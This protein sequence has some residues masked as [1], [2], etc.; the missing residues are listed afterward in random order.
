MTP[1]EMGLATGEEG[2]WVVVHKGEVVASGNNSGDM[3]R[4]AERYPEDEVIVTKILYPGAS[5]Y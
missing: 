4:F 1:I 3:L 5:F 2:K